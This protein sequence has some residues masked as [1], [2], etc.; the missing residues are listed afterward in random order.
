MRRNP[1]STITQSWTINADAW[2][3]EV[4]SGGIDSRERVTAAAKCPIPPAPTD[5]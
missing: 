3:R 4:P 5:S 1:E 2:T